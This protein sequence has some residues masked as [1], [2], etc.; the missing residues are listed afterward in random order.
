MTVLSGGLAG[1][2]GT[3]GDTL[4]TGLDA[5]GDV[6]HV[7]TDGFGPRDGGSGRLVQRLEDAFRG[8]FGPA[9]AMP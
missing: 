1:A 6:N 4:S 2:D 9:R 3:A 5:L 8:L 7:P